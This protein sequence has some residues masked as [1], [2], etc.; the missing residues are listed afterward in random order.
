MLLKFLH[1]PCTK[2]KATNRINSGLAALLIEV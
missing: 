2:E 1:L